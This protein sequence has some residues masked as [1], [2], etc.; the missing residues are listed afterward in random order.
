[1]AYQLP[2]DIDQ[3]VQSQIAL[4]VYQSPAEVLTEALNALD[5]YNEDL[6]SIRRGIE[7][8]KAGRLTSLEGFDRQIREQFGFSPR[9]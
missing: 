8:E 7:D 2:P 5:R 6:A 9:E 4:G 1:M 3:R